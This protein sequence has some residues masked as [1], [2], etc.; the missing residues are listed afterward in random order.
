MTAFWDFTLYIVV[1]LF[2]RFRRTFHILL[3]YM[4]KKSKETAINLT[5]PT[6]KPSELY[7]DCSGF[8]L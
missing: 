3:Y 8:V 1:S 6:V 4:R 7:N 2:Q 5:T